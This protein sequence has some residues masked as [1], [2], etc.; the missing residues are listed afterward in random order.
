M[1]ADCRPR[2]NAIWRQAKYLRESSL[3]RNAGW[4]LAGQGLSL[5]CQATY[6]VLLARL[7][8]STE[9]GIYVGA[10]ALVS[11]LSQY[12]PLGS[13]FVLLRHVSQDPEK[14][15]LYWG[16]VLI[17]CLT[18][19]STFVIL[20][21]WVGP[22]MAHSFSWKLILCVALGDCI[23]GQITDAASRVFQAFEKLRFTAFLAVFVNMCRTVLVGVMLWRLHHATA[24]VWVIAALVISSG[25][26]IAAVLLVTRHYGL[27]VFSLRLLVR[28]I[29][30][31]IVFALSSS[32]MNIYDNVDKAMLGHYGM[33]AANGVYSMAYRA[34]DVATM[35]ITSIHAAAFPHF[36]RKGAEGL[37]STTR[38]AT[39]IL[40]RTL[41]LSMVLVA[42]L[43]LTAPIIPWLA[44]PS[45]KESVDVLRWIC[46]LPL[47]R[48]FQ[49]SAGDA[50][51]G[52]GH[53]KLRLGIQASAAA[54]N[55]AVNL[56]LIPLYSWRGAASSSLAT[57]AL[58]GALNWTILL[59]LRAK[60]RGEPR[61]ALALQ[62]LR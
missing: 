25:A 30:E 42:A 60:L 37:E 17:T 39:D 51:T 43:A 1:S 29:G 2:L 33:N 20:L 53:L 62:E 55:F 28:H 54:F 59:I 52:A 3:A 38:W 34:V 8:G 13:Q 24:G 57:D 18:L 14:F 36:F 23:C 56:Y 46:L 5:V 16:N 40:K 35:P 31:G 61:K 9:Y 26:A 50:L 7:L 41:P 11:I 44:G 32:T 45:F 19:G 12:S 15:A 47:F 49:L 58:L 22:H 27:P 6:F 10:V 48:S 4:M 21:A